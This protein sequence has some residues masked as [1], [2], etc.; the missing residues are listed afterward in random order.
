MLFAHTVPYDI[1]ISEVAPPAADLG[2]FA[3]RYSVEAAEDLV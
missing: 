2:G 3:K 1:I